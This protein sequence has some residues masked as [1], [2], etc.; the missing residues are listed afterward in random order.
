MVE[1]KRERLI[2]EIQELREK[3]RDREAALP[4]HSVRPHQILEIEELEDKITALKK[5]LEETSRS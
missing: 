3:L 5:E 2:K 1:R 4:A